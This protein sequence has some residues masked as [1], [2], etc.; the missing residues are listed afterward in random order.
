MRRATPF[1]AIVWLVLS[2]EAASAGG[3]YL[4]VIDGSQVTIGNLHAAYASAGTVVTMQGDF[5]PGQQA[6]VSE[7]PWYAYLNPQEQSDRWSTEPMLLGSV[8]ISGDGFPYVAETTFEVPSVPAGYYRI[9]VC[10]LGCTQGV[11]DL[12]SGSIVLAPTETEARTFARA[13]LLGWAHANDVRT[14]AVMRA[15][16]QELRAEIHEAEKA[17]REAEA[18][19]EAATASASVASRQAAAAVA[20]QEDAERQRALW[21]FVGAGAV[22]AAFLML[23][24]AIFLRRRVQALIP[25]SPAELIE[26]PT[27]QR[28]VPR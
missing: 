8:D 13:L 7:G 3:S 6:A 1:I 12:D 28:S 15:R 21:R 24:W 27:D 9:L 23:V 19:S 2:A 5:T 18:R 14:I 16:Q 25:Q 4:D 10:D 20:S 17:A 11:G 26:Q 22:L